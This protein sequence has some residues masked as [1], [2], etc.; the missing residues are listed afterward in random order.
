MYGDGIGR[1]IH[2]LMLL[3]AIAGAVV[4]GICFWLIPWLWRMVKPWLHMVTG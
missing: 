3:C 1:A 2:G 4:M